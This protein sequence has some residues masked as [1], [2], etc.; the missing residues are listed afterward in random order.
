MPRIIDD[1]DP[2]Y[3]D[4]ID[5]NGIVRDGKAIRVSL[6]DSIRARGFAPPDLRPGGPFVQ[7]HRPGNWAPPDHRRALTSTEL[8]DARARIADAI[9]EHDYRDANAWRN[10]P[11]GPDTG[12]DPSYTGTGAPARGYG[13]IPAGSYPLSAG[14]G[15]RCT[16]DGQDGRLV[17]EG[18]WLVCRPTSND[19]RHVHKITQHD[20]M[21]REAATYEYQYESE[22]D[23]DERGQSNDALSLADAQQRLRDVRQSAFD[24]YDAEQRE[25]WRRPK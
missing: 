9:A 22:P 6:M 8:Q 12:A 1:D 10:P 13:K 24:A 15:G 19:A 21:G 17:R 3:L 7:D 23:D 5:E 18:N 4:A 20:P 25:A 16:I 11:R 2:R 14:E